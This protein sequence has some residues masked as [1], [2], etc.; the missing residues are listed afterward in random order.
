MT[1]IPLLQSILTGPA[2]DAEVYEAGVLVAASRAELSRV[3]VGVFVVRLRTVSSATDEGLAP[4]PGTVLHLRDWPRRRGRISRYGRGSVM[5]SAVAHG[6]KK[7]PERH[8]W[9]PLRSG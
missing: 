2:R 8:S 5:A 3:R 9:P 1:P 4:L 7:R 6:R